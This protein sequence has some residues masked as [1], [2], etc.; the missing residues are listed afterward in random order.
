MNSLQNVLTSKQGR[1][2]GLAYRMLGSRADAE[3]IL[4]YAHLKI[5]QLEEQEIR[6]AEAFLVTMITRMC[7]DQQKSARARREVYVG[8]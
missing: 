8:P 3:D 7:L 2:I 5:E 4:Q 6:N 1:F